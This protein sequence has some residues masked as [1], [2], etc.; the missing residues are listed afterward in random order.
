MIG[1]NKEYQK[2]GGLNM[3]KKT[4][5]KRKIAKYR[6]IK[7]FMPIYADYLHMQSIKQELKQA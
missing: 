4:K 6:Q 1:N 7:G 3:K 2:E 5:N